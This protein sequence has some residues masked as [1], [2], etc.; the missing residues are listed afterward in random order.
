M[1]NVSEIKISKLTN[2]IE[3]ITLKFI[4]CNFCVILSE[5]VGIDLIYI[6]RHMS[7]NDNYIAT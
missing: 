2:I 3:E 1:T 7:I 6:V 4:V 5:A